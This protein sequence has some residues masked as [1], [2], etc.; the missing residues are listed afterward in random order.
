[1]VGPPSSLSVLQQRVTLH[2]VVN[3]SV[4]QQSAVLVQL[5]LHQAVRYANLKMCQRIVKRRLLQR[6]GMNASA[7]N[8][9][10]A[11]SGTIVRMH[12]TCSRQRATLTVT[13]FCQ[14]LAM[15]RCFDA[16]WFIANLPSLVDGSET[17]FQQA[18][19]AQ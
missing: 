6:P 4:V 15:G 1:M 16:V 7:S 19:S 12:R 8:A 18:E 10:E 3:L 17:V 11:S 13:K 9:K 5:D 2:V 14:E